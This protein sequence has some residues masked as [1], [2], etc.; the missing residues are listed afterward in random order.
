MIR[1]KSSQVKSESEQG[2]QRRG[3]GGPLLYSTVLYQHPSPTLHHGRNL[4][5][6]TTPPYQQ[7]GTCLDGFDRGRLP[8]RRLGSLHHPSDQTNTHEVLISYLILAS[9]VPWWLN[10]ASL[11]DIGTVLY[12]SMLDLLVLVPPL[13]L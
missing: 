3:G 2:M 9:H 8:P 7:F 6:A 12:R 1:V 4:L 5:S 10:L 11:F 13:E